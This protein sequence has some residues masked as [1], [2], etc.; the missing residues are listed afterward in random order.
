MKMSDVG[1]DEMVSSLRMLVCPACGGRKQNRHTFCGGCYRELPVG[2]RQALYR[3]LGHG[4]EDAVRAAMVMLGV[5]EWTP[6][7]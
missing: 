6:P 7:S 3:M 1:P 4:Y 2:Q 5:A